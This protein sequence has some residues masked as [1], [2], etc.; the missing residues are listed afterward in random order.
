MIRSGLIR[1]NVFDWEMKVIYWYRLSDATPRQ[2]MRRSIWRKGTATLF[3]KKKKKKRKKGG[4]QGVAP[5]LRRLGLGRYLSEWLHRDYVRSTPG[6]F[7]EKRGATPR[8][9]YSYGYSYV[10]RPMPGHRLFQGVAARR[11]HEWSEASPLPSTTD[12]FPAA[13]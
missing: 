3:K 13:G 9:H 7:E 4:D 5:H 8:A 11:I 12:E 10:H 1:G 2:P 6:V